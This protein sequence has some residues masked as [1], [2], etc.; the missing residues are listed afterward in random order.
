[1]KLVMYNSSSM[2]YYTRVT[3]NCLVSLYITTAICCYDS[4]KCSIVNIH[5]CLLAITL[6]SNVMI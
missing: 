6:K 4:Y 3:A 2:E 5:R 1:M